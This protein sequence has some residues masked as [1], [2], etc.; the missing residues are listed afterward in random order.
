LQQGVFST[1]A[2]FDGALGIADVA[3]AA[4]QGDKLALGLLTEA[5]ERLGEA[6]SMALNLLGMDLVVVGGTLVHYSPRVLDAAARIVQLR[7]LPMVPHRR[8]LVPSALG[9]GAAA[10]GVA[11]QAID[12]LLDASLDGLEHDLDAAEESAI[13]AGA[14]S[15]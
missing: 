10:R 8:A 11:L 7:V 4:E 3:A 6:I 5:G 1:L 13:S 9:S 15:R 2:A 14:A 12:R